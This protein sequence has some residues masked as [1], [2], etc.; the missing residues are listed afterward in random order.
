[1]ISKQLK[2]LI[3]VNMLLLN[4][5]VTDRFRKKGF[6]GE[7]LTKRLFRQSAISTLLF[8]LLYGFLMATMD[9]SKMPGMFTFYV[10]L[11]ILL[12]FSQS[13]SGIYNVF[14][15]GKDLP[16]YL[17]LP[18]KQRD[19]F[20]SKIAVLSLNI[21]PF[22]LPMLLVFFATA[23]R[24]GMMIVVAVVWSIIG[25]LAV[26]SANYL[27]CTF[28]VFG[29]VKT[30]LFKKHQNLVMSSLM[31]ISMVIAIGGIMIMNMN[32]DTGSGTDRTP[33]NFLMPLYAVFNQPFSMESLLTWV[34]LIG[35]III[36]VLI[37]QKFVLPQ[38]GEQLT[39]V[40]SSLTSSSRR[41]KHSKRLSLDQSLDAYNRQLLTEP[42]LILQVVIN[43]VMV[44]LIFIISFAFADLSM[45]FDLKWIGVFFVSGMFLSIL[46]TNQSSLISN[47]ISLDRSNFEF[48]YSLPISMKKYLNRKFKLGYLFQIIVNLI[49]LIIMALVIK[50]S[51]R[52]VV[53]M[54][55]GML[56]GTYLVCL[57][58]FRRDFRLRSTN[59]TN[60]TELFNRGGGNIA[61]MLS[62]TL[63]ILVSILVI[64][65][66]SAGIFYLSS[67]FSWI[68]NCVVAAVIIIGG[69]VYYQNYRQK[70]WNQLL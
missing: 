4:P 44:P 12:S 9:F 70:F 16:N 50:L 27:I 60:I 51:W 49:I 56:L 34:V 1:M 19:I 61:M 35:A 13:I 36:L 58:F 65:I 47:L 39:S 17:P 18:F 32:A 8:V 15:A 63:N 30:K 54:I 10:A 37:L 42:N 69:F 45:N 21:V 48:V 7:S 6:T 38:L 5:Q 52:M 29:L 3:K 64:G 43:S 41:R 23:W 20:L 33:I 55:I 24:S 46:T 62:M 59:W 67:I 31:T 14:F 2:S 68:V 40:N 25:Y 22:T 53:A 66:Y 11:F 57:H 26:I 28:L